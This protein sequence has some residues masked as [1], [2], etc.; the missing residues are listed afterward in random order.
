M[1]KI[2]ERSEKS[3]SGIMTEGKVSSRLDD[4]FRGFCTRFFGILC[5]SIQE[6]SLVLENAY[7]I[8]VYN[9][10]NEIINAFL[11]KICYNMIRD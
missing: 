4:R 6:I 11:I 5:I 9:G 7:F 10:Q 2:I 8:N 1:F 3:S